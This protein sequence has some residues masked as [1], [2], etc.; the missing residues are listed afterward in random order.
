MTDRLSDEEFMR[1][2]RFERD[3]KLAETDPWALSDRTITPEQTAYRQALRDFP[4]N[5]VRPDEQLMPCLEN[6]NWPV[7]PQ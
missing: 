1:L 6:L 4:S 3:K 7:K 5:V 2:V